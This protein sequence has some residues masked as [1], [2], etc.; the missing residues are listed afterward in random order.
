MASVRP[1][2]VAA[3][4]P[5]GL[6]RVRQQQAG[7][8]GRREDVLLDGGVELV[9]LEGLGENAV[10]LVVGRFGLGVA[11][12]QHHGKGGGLVLQ[13]VGQLRPRHLGHAEIGK[14]DVVRA[15][16]E[17]LQRLRPRCGPV[18]LVAAE[19]EEARD[20]GTDHL[21]VV[22]HE[23]GHSLGR[24]RLVRRLVHG[25][26]GGGR[27]IAFGGREGEGKPRALAGLGG[28]VDGA[29]V[30]LHDAVAGR[31]AHAGAVVALC[32]EE[33]L[34]DVL[35]HL[36][37]HADARIADVHAHLPG[38]VRVG[39]EAERTALGHGLDGVQDEVDEHLAQ[40]G[41][42]PQNVRDVRQVGL[43]RDFNALAAGLVVP[44]RLGEGNAVLDQVRQAQGLEVLL[45]VVTDV[46]LELLDEG[47][48]VLRRRLDRLDG[49]ADRVRQ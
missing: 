21:L 25:I 47:R 23:D 39:V 38:P 9:A 43:D 24:C 41:R 6:P 26:L 32:G 8:S 19:R 4:A 7:R 10:H 29:L 28:H 48:A 3:D 5:A 42:G 31:E 14:H 34:E 17:H 20:G 27:R 13:G 36:V 11:G 35:L 1:S 33:G 22:H 40:L 18:N 45:R 46:A 16:G 15:G 30:L 44:V 12:Q 37:A 2:T 49:G